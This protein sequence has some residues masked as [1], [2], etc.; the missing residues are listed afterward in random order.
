MLKPLGEMILG[1]RMFTQSPGIIPQLLVDYTRE[2]Y[3][4]NGRG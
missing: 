3:V 4:C 1:D 2:M